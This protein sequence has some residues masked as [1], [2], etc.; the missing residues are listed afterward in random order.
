M[1][2]FVL[3]PSYRTGP[4]LL[5]TLDE[6]LAAWPTVWLVLDGEGTP[7]PPRPGLRVL[8]RTTNGGKGAAVL[9]ALAAAAAQGLTHALVMDADGQHPASHI[10]PFM[11]VS[12]ANPR[13]MILGVPEFG[14]EAPRLRVVGRRVS[15]WWTRLETAGAVHDSLFGFRV[16][17]VAPL[18]RIMQ[19]TRWMRRY[20]FDAEAA[21]RLVWAG[22]PALNL[23]A[24]VRYLTKAEGGISHFKYGRDNA[25]LTWMHVRLMVQFLARA[26]ARRPPAAA[27][28]PR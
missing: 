10:A 25:L 20:D 21:V 26:P 16:Y 5:Q 22:T 23:P 15:N 11:A 7:P 2:H 4:R 18:L 24:P 12:A 14:T 8:I 17:P 3:I 28:A 19:R 13:A 1:T 27:T 6:A 9:T